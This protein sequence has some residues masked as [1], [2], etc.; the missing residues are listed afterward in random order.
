MGITSWNCMTL[1][2][3]FQLSVEEE[4]NT[5]QQLYIF[6]DYDKEISSKFRGLSTSK[7]EIRIHGV[8]N[9]L[10]YISLPYKPKKNAWTTILIEWLG[11]KHHRQGIYTIDN[12]NSGVFIGNTPGLL[13]SNIMH[14]GGDSDGTK[15]LNGSI[16]S[17]ERSYTN[18]G[19]RRSYRRAKLRANLR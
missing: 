3:T 10:S 4:D 13:N 11:K 2:V 8:D 16:S 1:C 6:T 18:H 9:A 14:L 5:A 19:G 17:F 12:K 15:Y 7:N